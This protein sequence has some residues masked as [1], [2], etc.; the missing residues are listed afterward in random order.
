MLAPVNVCAHVWTPVVGKMAGTLSPAAI[1]RFLFQRDAFFRGFSGAL[2]C[3]LNKKTGERG[4]CRCFA[5]RLRMSYGILTVC[6]WFLPSC[7]TEIFP[8]QWTK[9]PSLKIYSSIFV[10]IHH[11][12]DSLKSSLVFVTVY[13]I[14]PVYL[15]I[16][17]FWLGRY[18][19]MCRMG[20][21]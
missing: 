8:K 1:G 5:L 10:N 4:F 16:G 9:S 21:N 6:W 15:L 14:L 20:F 19:I 18:L 7:D 3:Y 11:P 17:N 2:K 12:K 13:L